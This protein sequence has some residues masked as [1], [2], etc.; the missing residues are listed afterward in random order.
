MLWNLY[1]ELEVKRLKMFLKSNDIFTPF[2]DPVTALRIQCVYI[3]LK[4]YRTIWLFLMLVMK[5]A[6]GV[7]DFRTYQNPGINNIKSN[8]ILSHWNQPQFQCTEIQ[9]ITWV[10]QQLQTVYTYIYDS[11]KVLYNCISFVSYTLPWPQAT[12]AAA[13]SMHHRPWC[14][15]WVLCFFQLQCTFVWNK[16]Q[17]WSP[18]EYLLYPSPFFEI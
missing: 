15:I 2:L 3:L 7:L 8:V 17:F 6:I 13:K 16:N 9:K 10:L 18:F 4:C 12:K 11:L 5:S 14:I 1:E